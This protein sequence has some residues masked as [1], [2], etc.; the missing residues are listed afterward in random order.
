MVTQKSFVFPQ[1]LPHLANEIKYGLKLLL[2]KKHLYQK[3]NISLPKPEIIT[4]EMQRFLSGSSPSGNEPDL[5]TETLEF[6]FINSF[7]VII[8]SDEERGGYLDS[9]SEKKYDAVLFQPPTVKLFC[10]HCERI[11]AYNFLFGY[12]ILDEF[13]H[14]AENACLGSEQVF[15]L[16]YQCQSCKNTPE[17]FLVRREKL[18]LILSGRTP[19]EHIGTPSVLP[20]G[21]K[22]FFSDAILAYN[23]GQ[24]LAANFLLRTFIEQYVRSFHEQPEGK[25]IDE[26][27]SEYQSKLPD[28]FKR[29][30]PSLK[31]IYDKLSTDIHLAAGSEDVFIQSRNDVIKHFEAKKLFDL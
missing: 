15:S 13:R 12:D 9:G 5:S 3:V 29:R 17:V 27:F 10:Q 18:T 19:I 11:E 31:S 6:D 21:Y 1:V 22:R 7:W 28:D 26:M 23:S 25:N 30:F 20:K 24:T 8:K 4:D 2:E 14:T 16:V